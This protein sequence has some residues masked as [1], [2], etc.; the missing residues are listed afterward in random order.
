MNNVQYTTQEIRNLSRESIWNNS[1]KNV[2]SISKSG[3][4]KEKYTLHATG[5]ANLS[6]GRKYICL[7]SNKILTRDE[8]RK[9]NIL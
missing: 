1:I 6:D 3:N 8:K 2:Q 9:Y 5:D 7:P 4:N